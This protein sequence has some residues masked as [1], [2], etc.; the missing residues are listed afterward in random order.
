M[1]VDGE[2]SYTEDMNNA[3]ITKVQDAILE[4]CDVIANPGDS[5]ELCESIAAEL[6]AKHD[7]F[8]NDE[9]SRG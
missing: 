1:K 3:D 5:V 6:E 2:V 7:T 4:L 8:T 9:K